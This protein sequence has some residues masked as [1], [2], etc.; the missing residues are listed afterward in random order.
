MLARSFGAGA[1]APIEIVIAGRRDDPGPLERADAARVALLARHL[2]PTA[3]NDIAAVVATPGHDAM[4]LTVAPAT[5]IDSYRSEQLV[6]HIRE[7]A[8]ACCPGQWGLE[9]A[10][11]GASAKI[12]D[13]SKRNKRA[14]SRSCWV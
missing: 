14:K 12:V 3:H 10:V 11:G 2:A 5:A 6:R 1:L 9:V 8:A 13:L 4:L 7:D